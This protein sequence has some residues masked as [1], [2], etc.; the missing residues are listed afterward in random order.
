MTAKR[1]LLTALPLVLA[2]CGAGDDAVEEPETGEVEHLDPAVAEEIEATADAFFA[3]ILML[4]EP[5]ARAC[6]DMEAIGS[7][8]WE[9]YW[10]RLESFEL[11]IASV[12]ILGAE[13]PTD[14]DPPTAHVGVDA[15]I[16]VNGEAAT[17]EAYRLPLVETPEGWLLTALPFAE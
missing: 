5:E 3:E 1:A 10:R 6:V 8:E 9:E 14:S 12:T 11:E 2:G 7:D 13:P 17:V 15:E 4:H 16:L